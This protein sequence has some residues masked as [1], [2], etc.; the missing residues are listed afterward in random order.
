MSRGKYQDLDGDLESAQGK[1]E[2]QSLSPNKGHVLT[3]KVQVFHG[4]G[5]LETEN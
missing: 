5:S 3:E 1:C 4:K 2:V